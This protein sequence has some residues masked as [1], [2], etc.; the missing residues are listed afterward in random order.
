MEKMSEEFPNYSFPNDTTKPENAMTFGT[1]TSMCLIDKQKLY[2]QQ[3]LSCCSRFH[4]HFFSQIQPISRIFHP[5]IPLSNSKL[6][7]RSMINYYGANYSDSLVSHS[8]LEKCLE[9]DYEME[10]NQRQYDPFQG[11]ILHQQSLLNQDKALLL[12]PTGPAFTSLCVGI[13]NQSNYQW[14]STFE[15]EFNT[16]LLQ[17]TSNT[18][19]LVGIRTWDGMTLAKLNQQG[20][21]LLHFQR[22]SKKP[23]DLCLNP[24]LYQE[25]LTLFEDGMCVLDNLE[26]C[27]RISTLSQPQDALLNNL[28]WRGCIYG[29]HPRT[30]L[31]LSSSELFLMD[32]RQG[33]KKS[34]LLKSKELDAF[35]CHS[36]HPQHP[37][38][39]AIASKCNTSLYDTRYVKQALMEWDFQDQ[40]Y[41][42][43]HISMFSHSSNTNIVNTMT[44]N[45]RGHVYLYSCESQHPYPL[46]TLSVQ[47]CHP[48]LSLIC[49]NPSNLSRIHLPKKRDHHSNMKFRQSVADY[50]LLYGFNASL[51]DSNVLNTYYLM[52]N[53]AL[54]HGIYSKDSTKLNLPTDTSSLDNFIKEKESELALNEEKQSHSLQSHQML[55]IEDFLKDLNQQLTHE[56]LS[57]V[58]TKTNLVPTHPFDKVLNDS[59]E[60]LSVDPMFKT[61]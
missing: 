49:K 28:K 15:Y 38:Q 18:L 61:L 54:F 37:F 56:T 53:G 32:L 60:I 44:W 39:M 4:N 58:P 5:P 35:Y 33:N 9:Q 17:I 10:W 40:N 42:P 30:C 21:E 48:D 6:H 50:P 29:S 55:E 25:A 16:P 51:S 31:L 8:L 47:T 14:E 26:I 34:S 1:C 3:N 43:R 7:V 13:F 57:P 19:G 20:F 11:N 46:Q 52:E 23:L 36:R 24:T 59:L 12:Y 2:F 45:P 41:P 22:F 27:K